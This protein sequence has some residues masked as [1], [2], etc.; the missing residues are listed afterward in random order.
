MAKTKTVTNT[1]NVK[2]GNV[3]PTSKDIG[4]HYTKTELGVAKR[5]WQKG[6]TSV[7]KALYQFVT[8]KREYNNELHPDGV[9]IEVSKKFSPNDILKTK[10]RHIFVRFQEKGDREFEYIG[11]EAYI[12]RYDAKRCK[13][14][15]D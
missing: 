9:V 10:G 4:K 8:I 2:I 7:G 14:F 3:P 11:T 12:C 15:L 13:I 5:D 1:R 6:H